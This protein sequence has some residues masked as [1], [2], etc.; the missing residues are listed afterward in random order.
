MRLKAAF[1]GNLKEYMA[2]EFKAAEKAVTL[3]IRE[4]TQGLKM[5]MRRQAPQR[6]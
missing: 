2:A 1:E 6:A 5:S 4:A 3:G